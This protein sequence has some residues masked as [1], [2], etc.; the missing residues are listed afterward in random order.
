VTDHQQI[1][2]LIRRAGGTVGDAPDFDEIY[3]RARHRRT[4]R[5]AATAVVTVALAVVAGVGINAIPVQRTIE[6]LRTD[7]ERAVEV[8]TDASEGRATEA[9][10][11]GSFRVTIRHGSAPPFSAD[12]VDGQPRVVRSAQRF[13]APANWDG[14]GEADV[15]VDEQMVFEDEFYLRARTSAQGPARW[16]RY[17]GSRS[18]LT[19]F[20]SD[21]MRLP[22][23]TEEIQGF[24]R[25]EDPKAA[26]QGLARYS[27][28]DAP[29]A[30]IDFLVRYIRATPAEY[31]R[32]DEAT[33]DI[34]VDADRRVHRIKEVLHT[35]GG[36]VR[37]V[38]F[39]R[40]DAVGPLAPPFEEGEE[41]PVAADA[42][43]GV[44]H[45]CGDPA[46]ADTLRERLEAV[47]D[48]PEIVASYEIFDEPAW[49]Q[50]GNTPLSD[51]RLF[52]AAVRFGD[53]ITMD[54]A[55]LEEMRQDVGA[56][57]DGLSSGLPTEGEGS[58][59]VCKNHRKRWIDLEG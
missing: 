39:D 11:E 45:T 13:S 42:M 25:V 33:I 58:A 38:Q 16:Y 26:E 2:G 41:A 30:D 10:V 50:A 3:R 22:V 36:S 8:R 43:G 46:L 6:F 18:E 15:F 48:R 53:N 59:G 23:F 47:L 19:G 34:W 24:S 4:T 32:G 20:A 56:A 40:F 55:A 57:D 31:G 52:V 9:M 37:I 54:S 28:A 1:A 51:N 49:V 21:Q 44:I 7:R 5:I 17:T 27:A 29:A 12:V 35:D 14:F